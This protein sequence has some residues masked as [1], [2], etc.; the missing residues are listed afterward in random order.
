M[1]A[2]PRDASGKFTRKHEGCRVPGCARPHSCRGFC[3]MHAKAFAR[4][5]IRADGS[6]VRS[7]CEL[8]GAGYQARTAQSRFCSTCKPRR[9]RQ[10]E[11]AWRD[12]NRSWVRARMRRWK[13]QHRRRVR[14]L[15]AASA[16]R[17]RAQLRAEDQERYRQLLESNAARRERLQQLSLRHR[18]RKW[19]WTPQETAL[20][21][22]MYPA[23]VQDQDWERLFRTLGRTYVAIR[24]K[25]AALGKG[26]MR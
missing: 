8:C 3:K 22:R 17:R 20:L 14:Q 11:K 21:Q 13:Q 7:R 10:R 25:I 26:R 2:Q 12:A 16:R 4:G 9:A 6:L 15:N 1:T 23:I 24:A 18:R 19:R 5:R